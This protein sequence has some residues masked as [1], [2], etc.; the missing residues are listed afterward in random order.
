MSQRPRAGG[1]NPTLGAWLGGNSGCALCLAPTGKSEAGKAREHNPPCRGFRDDRQRGDVVSGCVVAGCELGAA[2][3]RIIELR[4]GERGSENVVVNVETRPSKLAMRASTR[5]TQFFGPG[6]F[7][8]ASR[9]PASGPR[10]AVE[11]P[12]TSEGVDLPSTVAVP[13]SSHVGQLAG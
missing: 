12:L 7:E 13:S 8:G 9:K 5:P 1:Q 3:R 11:G 4:D 6:V 2:F 10:R